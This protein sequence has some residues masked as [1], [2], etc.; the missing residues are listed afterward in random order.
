MA[1]DIDDI[2]KPKLG[3]IRSLGGARTKGYLNRVLRQVSKAG[4]SGFGTGAASRRYSGYRIGRG[5]DALRHRRAGH[6]FG[7]SYRRVVIKTRIVKLRSGGIDAARAHL[8]YI[9]RDGVSKEHEPGRLYDAAH[10]EADGK[11]FLDRSD[12]DRHQFRFIVSPEDATELANLKPFVRDLMGAM[13]KD[14]G[15]RLD[16]VAVDHFNTEHPHTHI[17]CGART[18]SARTLSSPA[19]TSPTACGGGRANC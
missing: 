5:N 8:R 1:D 4:K 11:A 6:R 14:L 3:R 7:P 18:S 15:T 19:T 9:Q 16:W 12:G 2:F 17:G 13:E 10:D